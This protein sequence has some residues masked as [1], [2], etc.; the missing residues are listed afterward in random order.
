M[1]DADGTEKVTASEGQIAAD[2]AKRLYLDRDF[3]QYD[4]SVLNSG[5]VNLSD[6][7]SNQI[8]YTDTAVTM[9][10]ALAEGLAAGSVFIVPGDAE[11]PYGIAKKVVSIQKDGDQAVIETE[12]P[13]LEEVFDN[14]DFSYVGAPEIENI[15]PAQDGV[16]VVSYSSVSGLAA[17]GRDTA[18][19]SLLASGSRGGGGISGGG[20]GGTGFGDDSDADDSTGVKTS[21][22]KGLSFGLK[23]NLT[24]GQLTPNAG[25][26][27]WFT[28]EYTQSYDKFFG[29]T[30][31]EDAGDL[32]KRTHT[33]IQY[34]KQ[35]NQTSE[36]R[37]EYTNGYEIIGS[38]SVKNLYLESAC[39]TKKLVGIPYGIESYT[40]QLHYEVEGKLSVKGKLGVEEMIY[41]TVIPGP[42]GIWNEIKFYVCIDFNGEV[43]VKAT[44]EHT[45]N[46]TYTD[47]NYRKT[48]DTDVTREFEMSATLWSGLKGKVVLKVLGIAIVD[49]EAKAGAGM[50][51]K[52]TLHM[53]S[54]VLPEDSTL[55]KAMV[56][57]DFTAYFP[58]VSVSVGMD[59]QTLAN[60]LGLKMKFNLVD[61][62]HALIASAQKTL[63]H[64]EISSKGMQIVPEC[65]WKDYVADDGADASASPDLSISPDV[66][67]SPSDN[68]FAALVLQDAILT[69]GPGE[70]K[71]IVITAYPDNVTG[72]DIRYSSLDTSVA[73]VDSS[74]RVT[75]VASGTT[76]I[77][78]TASD[79]SEQY[80][81][82]TVTNSGDS[83][84]SHSFL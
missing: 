52:S 27:D 42:W 71:Q 66:S 62:K 78:V 33:V 16:T 25:F 45:S 22:T 36:T 18:H 43:S 77:R 24:K 80:C 20:G 1:A 56:C 49:A 5:V 30:I 26:G 34:D 8:T 12:Q 6:L 58:T 10:A 51:V 60:K 29:S 19:I 59:S 84:G 15:K 70:S 2:T 46:V 83:G 40:S 28:S 39:E 54:Q 41:S 73:T 4:N 67:V 65:T 76:Q 31:G 38:L 63:F 72:A 32:L 9:S 57:I 17:E 79:G 61:R 75:G 21:D 48:S 14:L 44:L 11:N 53:Q 82:I 23:I 3:P 50:D 35:G 55:P 47:G 74:G 37:D 13:E 81:A 7:S 69:M 64:Y 68:P